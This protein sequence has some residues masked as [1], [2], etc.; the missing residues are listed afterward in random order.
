MLQVDAVIDESPGRNPPVHAQM[1]Q[2]GIQKLLVF[3]WQHLSRHPRVPQSGIHEFPIETSG[4]TS[5]SVR[6]ICQRLEAAVSLLSLVSA[7]SS[8][9]GAGS[10]A[11]LKYFLRSSASSLLAS[12]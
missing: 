4:M 11:G 6:S 9:F 5:K 10:T 2:I 12:S 7:F 3:F 1:L 8:A